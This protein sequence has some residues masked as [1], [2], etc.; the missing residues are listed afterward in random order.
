MKRKHILV[1]VGLLGASMS[2]SACGGDDADSGTADD[3]GSD[4]SSSD[5]QCP[6]VEDPVMTLTAS[7]GPVD[8]GLLTPLRSSKGALLAA[9]LRP[10]MVALGVLVV[11]VLIKQLAFAT[12]RSLRS[13]T[14]VETP[15]IRPPRRTTTRRWQR[16]ADSFDEQQPG[17]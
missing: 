8:T 3:S 2:L 16:R 7:G 4:S 1:M 17:P 13:A 5:L 11:L 6:Q 9:V 14:V 15:V 10:L 12:G